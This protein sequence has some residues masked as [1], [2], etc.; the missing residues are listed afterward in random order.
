[1]AG[2]SPGAPNRLGVASR[3]LVLFAGV[4]RGNQGSKRGR[5]LGCRG[6]H[7]P[8]CLRSSPGSVGSL[9]D[10]GVPRPF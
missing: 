5:G 4:S 7:G 6:Q 2:R 3:K 8:L 10:L 1:M 9:W